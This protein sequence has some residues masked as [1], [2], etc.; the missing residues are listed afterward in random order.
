VVQVM[1]GKVEG[2]PEGGGGGKTA[3]AGGLERKGRGKKLKRENAF[4]GG[5]TIWKVLSGIWG[6]GKK[7]KRSRIKKEKKKA[8]KTEETPKHIRGEP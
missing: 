3:F 7:D 8:P 1:R 5:V 2:G 6:V 4:A